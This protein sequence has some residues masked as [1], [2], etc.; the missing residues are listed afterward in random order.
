MARNYAFVRIAIPHDKL[1][2][3]LIAITNLRD[4]SLLARLTLT[5]RL[6]ANVSIYVIDTEFAGARASELS[7]MQVRRVTTAGARFYF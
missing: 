1:D 4:G 6:G 5:R 3:E 7:Y 2:A